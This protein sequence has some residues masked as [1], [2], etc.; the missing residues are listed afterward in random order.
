MTNDEISEMLIRIDEKLITL[1]TMH[2]DHEIRLRQL[3]KPNVDHET[4][5][6]DLERND[7]GRFV[8]LLIGIL[9]VVS[10]VVSVVSAL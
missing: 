1:I 10:L 8:P 4:R 6:R 5:I 3:E 9:T 7:L 2:S